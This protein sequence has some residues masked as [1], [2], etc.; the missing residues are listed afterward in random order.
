[1]TASEIEET[2]MTESPKHR[3]WVIA[4]RLVAALGGMIVVAAL[5]FDW[6]ASETPYSSAGKDQ[7]LLLAAGLIL[8]FLGT[9]GFRA[10]SY[11]RTAIV[12]LVNTVLLLLFLELSASIGVRGV[13][14]VAGIGRP[15]EEAYLDFPYYSA[16]DW[17]E[18]HWQEARLARTQQYVPYVV[19]REAPYEGQ[20]ININQD[21]IRATPGAHCVKDAYHVFAFGG[22]SLWGYGSPDWATIPALIQAELDSVVNEPV[23]VTNFGEPGFVTTQELVELLRQLQLGN[24]PDLVI[25]YDGINDVYAA[26]QSGR[27]GVHHN[28]DSIEAK[29]EGGTTNLLSEWIGKSTLVSILLKLA[30][31]PLVTYRTMGVDLDELADATAA[32]YLSNYRSVA[33]LA[34]EYGF[35]YLFYWQP[36]ISVGDKSLAEEERRIK[37]AIDPDLLA[38]WDVVYQDIEMISADYDQLNFIADV[39]EQENTQIWIDWTHVT[40]IGNQLVAERMMEDITRQVNSSESLG[41]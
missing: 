16:Q 31:P 22:S 4:R 30:D 10:I 2:D 36:A 32:A 3:R 24:V 39:F 14:W 19:W 12:I 5:A 20:T 1:M 37:S 35:D 15:F 21:G 17:A 7:A 13:S 25:F 26:Y 41:Q 6:S 9:F 33:A 38:L 40:P 29:V 18:V 27:P 11:Y 8:L 28:L 34:G 23:C